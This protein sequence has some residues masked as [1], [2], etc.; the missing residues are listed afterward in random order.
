MT[1]DA[2]LL[3]RKSF[4][5]VES[6]G[7]VAALVFYQHLFAL[8]PALRPLFRNDIEAQAQKLIEM[9]SAALGLLERPAELRVTLEQLGARHVAYGVEPAHYATVGSALL[10]M[11]GTVLGA[12]F[13]PEVR[14]AW[15]GL[16]GV[17]SETMLAGAAKVTPPAR[18]QTAAAAR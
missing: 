7:H 6:Q 16:Y 4:E 5:R 13:T 2:K 9:L 15:T 8:D 3:L 10:A 12:D 1:P 11:L 17:V 18:H 14:A